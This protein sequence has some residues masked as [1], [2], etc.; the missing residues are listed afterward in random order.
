[1]MA[2]GRGWRGGTILAIAGLSG[3]GALATV[4]SVVVG[5]RM[6]VFINI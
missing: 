2:V 3:A 4:E 5:L 6:Y 1:M